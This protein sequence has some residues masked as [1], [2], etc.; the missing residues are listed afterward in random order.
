MPIQRRTGDNS[1][2]FERRR[3]ATNAYQTATSHASTM[4]NSIEQ[5]GC[6]SVNF[7]A[8]NLASGVYYYRLQAGNYVET[9]KLL[10][11]R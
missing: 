11:L 8:N 1:I 9:R 6:K 5:P 7:N 2:S 10:L 3:A 4:P